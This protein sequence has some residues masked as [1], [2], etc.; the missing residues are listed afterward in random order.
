MFSRDKMT[1]KPGNIIYF[2]YNVSG[3]SPSLG[4]LVGH[5]VPTKV[6]SFQKMNQLFNFYV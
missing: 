1:N 4:W 3:H 6:L 2:V 5:S